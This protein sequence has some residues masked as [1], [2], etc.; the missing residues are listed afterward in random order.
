MKSYNN[1]LHVLT[2][3]TEPERPNRLLYDASSATHYHPDPQLD[4]SCLAALGKV[5]TVLP[6]ITEACQFVGRTWR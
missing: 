1:E 3:K 4:Q 2:S 5:S 6:I